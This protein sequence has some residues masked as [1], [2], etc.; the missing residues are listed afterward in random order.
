MK[1][2]RIKK[3]ITFI[4]A[5]TM[6]L[7]LLL[8][9]C[10]SKGSTD[11]T[12]TTAATTVAQ[13][14]SAETTAAETLD[15]Y[16]IVWYTIGTPMKDVDLVM[17]EVS[18]YTKEKINATVKMEIFD[19]SK[20]GEKMQVIIQSGE[21]F[22]LCFTCSWALPYE[23]TVAKNAFLPLDDLLEK[24]GQGIKE[25]LSPI[26]IDG[27]KV[28]GKLYAIAANKELAPEI[29]WVFNKELVDKYKFDLTT[30]KSYESLEPM[31][32]VIKE[33]EPSVTDP[34]FWPGEIQMQVDNLGGSTPLCVAYDSTD[35]KIQNEYEMPEYISKVKTLHKYYQAGYIR[36]D[37]ATFS[38]LDI[39]R[40]KNWFASL[41]ACTPGYEEASMQ[42]GKTRLVTVP[43]FDS[44]YVSNY[45]VAGAMTGISVTSKDPARAMMFMNLM[46][47]D[48]TLKNMLD[49]GIEG[50]HYKMEDG[51]Q[52]DLD[53]GT[54]DYDIS[55]WS[56][57]NIFLD[58]LTKADPADLWDQYAQ[59]NNSAKRSPILGFR[60]DFES[61]KKEVTAFSN[62]GTEFGKLLY[63]GVID[64]DTIYP[65]YLA[66]MKA[67]GFD[68]VQELMQ[69]Q[70]DAW[71]TAN[72]K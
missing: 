30:V 38:G 47:T 34:F 69:T 19:W 13:A 22:D 56:F 45:H 29:R 51:R 16:N 60:P 20:Y 11:T 58:N 59:L 54:Q 18:K 14:G 5:L 70:L 4:I 33:N 41:E 37:I 28:N 23:Q 6:L 3:C 24:Y 39:Y 35:F 12:P 65:K 7:E 36:K 57:G 71:K 64:Y 32:K 21:P 61:V 17:D 25:S 67:A 52:V 50:T 44:T 1:N 40:T 8:T 15:P 9:G 53:R 27:N 48:K 2:L 26:F 72:G 63:C 31:L 10:G 66:K 46:H 49:S 42:E 43:M 55:T 62:I 68:K